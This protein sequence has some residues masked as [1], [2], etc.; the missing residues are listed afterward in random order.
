MKNL[1]V[2]CRQENERSIQLVSALKRKSKFWRMWILEHMTSWLD[3]RSRIFQR[4]NHC[5]IDF[6]G[7]FVVNICAIRYRTA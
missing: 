2:S 6:T 5:T 4:I 3:V 1:K 7:I